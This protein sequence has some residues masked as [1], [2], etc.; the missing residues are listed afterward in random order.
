MDHIRLARSAVTKTV[1]RLRAARPAPSKLAVA[2]WKPNYCIVNIYRHGDDY[3][4]IHSDPLTSLGPQCIIGSLSL[5]AVRAFALFTCTPNADGCW[6]LGRCS[7]DVQAAA[8]RP[9]PECWCA[10]DFL[11]PAATQLAPHYVGG[12]PRVLPPRGVPNISARHACVHASTTADVAQVPRESCRDHPISGPMRINLTLRQ[13]RYE[14]SNRAPICACGA[15]TKLKPVLKAG[16]HRGRYCWLCPSH[17]GPSCGFFQ[18][19]DELVTAGK[20]QSIAEK[21]GH[22]K[23]DEK[24]AWLKHRKV[25]QDIKNSHHDQAKKR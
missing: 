4:G 21:M 20:R 16:P 18:W 5:G 8:C 2:Q 10:I 9:R 15:R 12:L 3:T 6:G 14:W 1:Q 7:T 13:R 25:M 11:D 23:G 17:R 19:D 22:R 24:M